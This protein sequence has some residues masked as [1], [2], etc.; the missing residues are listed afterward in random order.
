MLFCTEELPVAY[1]KFMILNFKFVYILIFLFI[2]SNISYFVQQGKILKQSFD[3]KA[4]K[5]DDTIQA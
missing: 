5:Y 2:L 4:T 3:K 1:F